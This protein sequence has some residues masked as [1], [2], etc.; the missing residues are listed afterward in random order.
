VLIFLEI[1]N[2]HIF[3]AI[4]QQMMKTLI[5]YSVFV[6]YIIWKNVV[7]IMLILKTVLKIVPGV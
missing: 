3:L 2:V 7:G 1:M 5:V 4:K 6:R